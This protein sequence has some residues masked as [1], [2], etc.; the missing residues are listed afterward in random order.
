MPDKDQIG[1]EWLDLDDL[2]NHRLYPQ[3]MRP[4]LKELKFHSKTYLGDIN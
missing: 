3:E 2:Q 1:V 4:F